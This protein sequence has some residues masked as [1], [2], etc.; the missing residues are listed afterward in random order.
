VRSWPRR[1]PARKVFQ[2]P[3]ISKSGDLPRG[4]TAPYPTAMPSPAL[5]FGRYSKIAGFVKTRMTRIRIMIITGRIS[6]GREAFFP[7]RPDYPRDILCCLQ[8]R[9]SHTRGHLRR[10]LVARH[11]G[12]TTQWWRTTEMITPCKSR[13]ISTEVQSVRSLPH[14]RAERGNLPKG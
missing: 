5:P 8:L 3:I 11:S 4:G 6:F 7:R 14:H 1:P 12:G 10:R 13:V 9:S 2:S